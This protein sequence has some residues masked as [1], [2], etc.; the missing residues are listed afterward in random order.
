MRLFIPFQQSNLP[1]NHLNQQESLLK[2][3][4]YVVQMPL[5]PRKS[6]CQKIDYSR[7]SGDV[8]GC[9]LKR[10]VAGRALDLRAGLVLGP[11][12]IQ[13]IAHIIF[14]SRAHVQ[15]DQP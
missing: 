4:N 13:R 5:I 7:L 12:K 11:N 15:H 8:D 6:Q 2:N 14:L 1:K 3:E 9:G 10:K